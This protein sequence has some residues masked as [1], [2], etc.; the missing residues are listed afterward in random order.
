MT[1]HILL[2]QLDPDR[3]ATMSR[4]ILIGLLR[5]ELGFTGVIVSDALDMAGASAEHG[6][7]DAAVR[8]LRA[9]CDLLCL[10]TDNTDDELT[11]IERGVRTAIADG[12][13]AAG[14][15][16]DAAERLR[17][18]ADDLAASRP[19]YPPGGA[20]SPWSGRLPEL[21]AA[22]DVQLAARTWRARTSGRYA[23]VRLEARPNSAVGP[24]AWGPF[25]EVARD[26]ESA[27]NAAFAA[28]PHYTVTADDPLPGALAP[29]ES[30][31]VV[32]RDIHRHAFARTAV[33]QLRR[34]QA[35]VLVVDMG[36]P[37]DDRR[38]A[39]VATFGSSTVMGQA[40]LAV[41]AAGPDVDQPV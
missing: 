14:R 26:P 29:N 37:S 2:P 18:L 21:V 20:G 34:V 30:V 38:Y 39:D 32:G 27:I 33:D 35:N 24:T 3:P 16:S 23:V 1:S 6:V 5:D 7:P 13:L 9:G 12:S 22:I 8:S 41:L 25:A 4:D 11:A 10:G 40:V 15:V 31:L 36:W 28:Q 19:P 17:T